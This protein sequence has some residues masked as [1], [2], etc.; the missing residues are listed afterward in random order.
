ML[1]HGLSTNLRSWQ[2]AALAALTALAAA[3]AAS[4]VQG[5]ASFT[6]SFVAVCSNVLVADW[7]SGV[8]AGGRVIAL[9]AWG[10]IGVS[11]LRA[12]SF[13]GRAAFEGA[14]LR[15]RLRRQGTV[16]SRK[17]EHAAAAI[18]MDVPAVIED[19]DPYAFTFGLFRP[20]VIV[21]SGLLGRMS[22]GEVKAVLRH[23]QRHLLRR[24][25]LRASM[26]EFLRTTFFWLPVLGDIADHC[27]LGREIAADRAASANDSR[28]ILASAL[29]KITPSPRYAAF[30]GAVSFG[31]FSHR[32]DALAYPSDRT[33][34]R[35]T[36]WRLAATVGIL[37]ALFAGGNAGAATD[38]G[39]DRLCVDVA[40]GGTAVAGFT[41]FIRVMTDAAPMS[42]AG[43]MTPDVR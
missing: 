25:P 24:D 28:R 5:I 9:A 18:G 1:A 16:I 8:S 26:A 15:R 29:L 22:L 13:A 35:I 39:P 42:E 10:L 30:S 27:A 19:A 34:L 14:A 7:G 41:P 3:V 43:Q 21:S 4:Q 17:A 11:V 32:V 33:P 31:Q 2:T 20:S 12:A 40:S 38:A 6:A 37:A 23:E 36:T